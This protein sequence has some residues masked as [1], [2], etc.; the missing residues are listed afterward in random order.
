MRKQERCERVKGK[1]GVSSSRCESTDHREEFSTSD[2][3]ERSV[4]VSFSP[5]SLFVSLSL[6]FLSSNFSYNNNINLK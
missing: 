2:Q 1:G 6:F 5:K 3:E 4:F